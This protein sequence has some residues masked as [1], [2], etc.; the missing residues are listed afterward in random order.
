M[1]A[2]LVLSGARVVLPTGVVENGRVIV[3][4]TAIAGA[5]PADAPSLDL[6]G[7]WVVPGFVDMHNHGGGGASFTNGT[8]ED[9]LKGV[10]THRLHGSTTVV[11]STVTGEM[12]V[13]AQRAALLSQLVD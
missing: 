13:L 6:A 5:A 10:H 12:D 7:H 8:V 3:D 9:V 1:A 2:S 4:G 11:A